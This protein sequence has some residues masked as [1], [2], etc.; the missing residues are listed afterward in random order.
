MPQ[1]GGHIAT[2]M[3]FYSDHSRDPHQLQYAAIS[4]EFHVVPVGNSRYNSAT[5]HQRVV[6]CSPQDIPIQFAALCRDTTDA[7]DLGTIQVFHRASRVAPR[8]GLSATPWDGNSYAVHGDVV[9]RQCNIVPF[10]TNFFQRLQGT[11]RVLTVEALHQH[12]AGNPNDQ[13][14]GPFAAGDANTEEVG[15]RPCTFIP[16]R[17]V[18]L[19]LNTNLPP[20]EAFLRLA[21]AITANNDQQACQPLLDFLR[22]ALTR[23]QANQPSA[24]AMA[25]PHLPRPP[26]SVLIGHFQAMVNRDLPHLLPPPPGTNTSAVATQIGELVAESRLSRQEALAR[27]QRTSTVEDLFGEVGLRTLMRLCQ[28]HNSAHLPDVYHEL[29][30]APK[31]QRQSVVQQ[32]F[33]SGGQALG[34]YHRFLVPPGIVDKLVNLEWFSADPND[35]STGLNPFLFGQPTPS[36][37]VQ[38]AHHIRMQ[39][40]INS[41]EAAP[42]LTDARFLSTPAAVRCPMTLPDSGYNMSNFHL[43]CFRYLGDSHPASLAMAMHRRSLDRHMHWLMT[44]PHPMLPCL[45]LRY[46]QRRFVFWASEQAV[47]DHQIPFPMR[48]IISDAA[49]GDFSWQIAMPPDYLRPFP[50]TPYQ[51]GAPSPAPAAPPPASLAPAP[52]RLPSGTP[53]PAPAPAQSVVRREGGGDPRFQSIADRNIA[54]RTIKDKIRRGDIP[55]PVDAQGRQRCLAWVCKGI[56]NTRCGQAHDHRANHTEEEQQTLLAWCTEHWVA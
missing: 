28:V 6:Q 39:A 17:Y 29:A 48:D 31:K 43:L 20:R 47:C 42:S 24:A 7:Q 27:S 18:A 33:T 53:A 19:L 14:V 10:P 1:P 51:G 49:C 30:A 32:A 25:W 22:V 56:C 52:A 4:A 36:E 9:Q 3:D 15:T 26:D 34:L 40:I 46:I 35:L 2:Y 45:L 16:F 8:P 41:G 37:E 55:A 50:A 13:M 5:L 23:S 44:L 54:T 11:V 12:L 38:L 21:P